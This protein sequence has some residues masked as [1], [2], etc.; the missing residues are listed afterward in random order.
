MFIDLLRGT[1][2]IFAALGVITPLLW[3]LSKEDTREEV[4]EFIGRATVHQP[5]PETLPMPGPETLIIDMRPT[6][7][8]RAPVVDLLGE[9]SPWE[10]PIEQPLV[11]SHVL[12][13]RRWQTLDPTE[14]GLVAA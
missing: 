11:M 9:W 6:P 4:E 12:V 8:D 1:V 10:Y 3:W 5:M 7:E 14:M 13:S 2:V